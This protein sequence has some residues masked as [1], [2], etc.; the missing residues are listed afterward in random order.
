VNGDRKLELIVSENRPLQTPTADIHGPFDGSPRLVDGISAALL[1][2]IKG[3]PYCSYASLGRFEEGE[4][5]YSH[6]APSEVE[7]G[8]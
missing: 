1:R 4:Q 3:D 7:E 5:R 8:S 2:K 6:R